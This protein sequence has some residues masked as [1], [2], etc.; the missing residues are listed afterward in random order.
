L[1]SYDHEVIAEGYM[2]SSRVYEHVCVYV[3]VHHLYNEFIIL[4]FS[5]RDKEISLS[6]FR[7]V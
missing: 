1:C 7:Y 4:H 6:V 3:Y 5:L 2:H